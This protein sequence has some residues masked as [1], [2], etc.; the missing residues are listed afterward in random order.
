MISLRRM[1][2]LNLLVAC[3]TLAALLIAGF[4]YQQRSHDYARIVTAS[5][6]S[7]FHFSN[8]RE[9]ALEALLA[10]NKLQLQDSAA[11][12]EKIHGRLLA[13]QEDRSLPASSRL[14]LLQDMDLA[15]AVIALRRLAGSS[16]PE[17]DRLALLGQLRQLHSQFVRFDR[18]VVSDMKERLLAFQRMALVIAGLLI[19]LLIF[20]LLRL[21]KRLLVPV[22]Q[23]VSQLD[24]NG[25]EPFQAAIQS[26]EEIVRLVDR[27]NRRA[28]GPVDN[29]ESANLSQQRR[30]E[31]LAAVA[32]EVVN[33]LNGIINYSQLLTDYCADLQV[34]GEQ[35]GMLQAII[36]E[37]EQ[38]AE[39]LHKAM[40]GERI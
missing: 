19:T 35:K 30:E 21:Y 9:Q 1:V 36:R 37:G 23:L 5:E 29:Q 15:G 8:S 22:Q 24:S 38:A 3:L 4:F 14:A 28:A 26:S 7:I 20:T 39:I 13:L 34:E 27:L 12:L 16:Q 17:S 18:V 6:E 32:N 31:A 2:T 33:H 10:G 11:Q 40:Q 25:A